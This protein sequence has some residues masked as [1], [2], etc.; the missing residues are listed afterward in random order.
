MDQP[1][2]SAEQIVDNAVAEGG[3]YEVIRQRLIDQGRQLHEHSAQL[4]DQRLE[5][6]GSS[7]MRVTARVRVRTENN[8]VARDIVQVGDLILFG[9]NVFIGLK[10]ETRI[11][12]VFALFREQRSDEGYELQRAPIAGSFLDQP[13]FRNDFDELYRYYKHTRLSRLAVRDGKLLAAFQIGERLQDIRVFRW[14]LSPDRKSAT[15]LDNRG[16]RDIALPPRFDFE[17][18]EATREDTVEGRHPHVNILDRLFV[19]TLGG[20][21]TVKVENN[22]EDGL[23]IYREAVEDSTQ[24]L[25]DAEFHYARVGALILLR[26]LPY[27][28]EQWRYLVFNTLNESVHRFDAIGQSCVQL[29]EDHGI[30]FPGGYYLSSGEHKT[31]DGSA[32]DLQFNRTIRSPNGEDVL[33]VFYD[34]DQ[35]RV[36]LFGYN[37]I[38]KSLL[39]PLTGHGYALSETGRLILFVS[40]NEPTRIHPMEIWETPYVSDEFAS[41]QPPSQNFLG[42]AGN[43]A[44]VR[45]VSDLFAVCRM[46]DNQSVSAR[47]YEELSAGARKMFDAHYWLEAPETASIHT[48]LTQIVDTSELVID[49]F[50]KV[51]SIRQDSA[52]AMQDAET[53]QQELL[54]T[55]QYQEMDSAEHYVQALSKLRRQRG[56]LTTTRE[57][58]YIDVTRIDTLSEEIAT[59]ETRLTERTVQF[60]SAD[61]ALAPY[62]AKVESLNTQIRKVT[63]VAELTPH[64]Q[65]LDET[66][67]GLD[68]LMELMATLKVAD[69]TLRT[70]IIDAI[71][72]VYG[73]V[74][75]AKALG[76]TTR[77]SLGSEE[78]VA[79]F[80]AQFKLFSQSINNALGMATTPERCDE[81]LSRLLVQL[82]EL[83]SQFVDHDQFLADIVTKREEL[84]E[85]FEAHRQQLVDS[86]QRKAQSTS[87]AAGRI[88]ASIEKR[89]LKFIEEDDLNTY[90]ASDAMVA[91]T[92]ELCE[93]LRELEASVQADDIDARLKA[94]RAQAVRSLRDKSDL[95]ETQLA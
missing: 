34:P 27:R 86:R 79:E 77:N 72:D 80:S 49:E 83:E 39:N 9:Y 68:L 29:P 13:G 32:G 21:L 55:I 93:H 7:E 16:E 5:E 54:R 25:A 33:Y 48:L 51:N 58:R 2:T 74:N 57:L 81:Q 60:L 15:Y 42:R 85:A 8:C 17:W 95:F 45:G 92:R 87:D 67:A 46:I 30:I 62:L 70:R 50:E 66:A 31:F 91:K 12:D 35:G 69:A 3:A 36:G 65:T 63:T 56:H 26:V 24:S 52:R 61:D 28:E 88:L 22:T 18:T 40:E 10:K 71:S 47:L 37:M 14:T 90:F 59:A 89:S 75:Q 4:N 6:F 53:A 64:L 1:A 73:A 94:I 84:Y 41:R 20:T 78:A 11:E 82:E 19:Q 23:G 38:N 76:R 43:A 44:L